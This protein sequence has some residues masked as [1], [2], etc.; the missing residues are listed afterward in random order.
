MLPRL[1]ELLPGRLASLLPSSL[2]GAVVL[3]VQP[4]VL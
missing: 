2:L 1:L 4:T 3:A